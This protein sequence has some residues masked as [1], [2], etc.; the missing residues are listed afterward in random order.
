MIFGVKKMAAPI[1]G[2]GHF[3]KAEVGHSYLAPKAFLNE[4]NAVVGIPTTHGDENGIGV[5]A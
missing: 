3:C 1:G 4:R 5:A 2:L